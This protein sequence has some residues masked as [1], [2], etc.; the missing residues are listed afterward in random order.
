M[1]SYLEGDSLLR[2]IQK[3]LGNE[4][5]EEDCCDEDD[6]D[7]LIGTSMDRQPE[8]NS[9]KNKSQSSQLKSG[10]FTRPSSSMTYHTQSSGIVGRKRK[11]KVDTSQFQHKIH[12]KKSL[13]SSS[14][15]KSCSPIK[16][17][18]APESVTD[19]KQL[20]SK[21]HNLKKQ[22]V[23]SFSNQYNNNKSNQKKS[24]AAAPCHATSTSS[25]KMQYHSHLR[26]QM[27]SRLSNNFATNKSNKKTH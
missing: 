11:S 1:M 25:N 17:Q 22:Q 7:G 2:D 24:H 21:I 23:S 15:S 19:T 27:G 16:P 18:A 6:E 13:S 3:S 4:E 10:S 5:M 8:P 9:G 20:T 12:N 26:S 14:N